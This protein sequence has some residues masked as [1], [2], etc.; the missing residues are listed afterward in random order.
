[1][2]T[3][4]WVAYEAE[5]ES[6]CRMPRNESLD[7]DTDGWAVRHVKMYGFPIAEWTTM[8]SLTDVVGVAYVPDTSKV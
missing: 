1:M 6:G 7:D 2:T 5:E 4:F 3:D 8:D